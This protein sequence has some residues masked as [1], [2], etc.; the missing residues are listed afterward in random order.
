MWRFSFV[1]ALACGTAQFNVVQA[2]VTSPDPSHLCVSLDKLFKERLPSMGSKSWFTFQL[3]R[4]GEVR[5]LVFT[6]W[7]APSSSPSTAKWLVASRHGPE[8]PDYCIQ[9]TGDEVQPLVSLHDTNFSEPFG[10]PGSNYPRCG[11]RDDPLQSVKV[12]A[13]AS[14]ELGDS[15]VLALLGAAPNTPNFILLMAKTNNHWVLIDQKPQTA[16][17]YY[18]RGGLSE[19]ETIQLK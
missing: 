12:R 11:K 7:D 9:A 18:D 8:R 2:E 10:M 1:V 17:C 13:W 15:L 4:D 14:R 16:S 5:H 6:Q 19:G 3:K